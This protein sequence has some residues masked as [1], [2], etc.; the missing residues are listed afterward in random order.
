MVKFT[1]HCLRFQL[2]KEEEEEV[3]EE[4][5][6]FSGPSGAFIK[7]LGSLNVTNYVKMSLHT[8]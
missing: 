7:L 6:L 1:L 5:E 8:H 4:E 2:H 3:K